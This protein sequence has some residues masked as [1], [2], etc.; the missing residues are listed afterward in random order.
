LA[1]REGAD[2][3]SASVAAVLGTASD[4][5]ALATEFWSDSFVIGFVMNVF[6][7]MCKIS[8]GDKLSSEQRGNLVTEVLK[9][10]G[11]YSPNFMGRV[12]KLARD[13]DPDFMLGGRNAETIIVYLYNL[14]PMQG[15]SDVAAA[16]EIAK[17]MTLT[18]NVGREEIGGTL[19]YTLFTLE[20]QKRLGVRG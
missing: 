5:R 13:H 10:V 16:T 1:S 20:V 11:G 7:I 17:G 19:M 3:L 9:D 12:L 4:I 8:T 6:N 2:G 14:D 18:G 15:D